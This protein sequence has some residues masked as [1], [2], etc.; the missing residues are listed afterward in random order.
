MKELFQ[1][2]P[3]WN[4]RLNWFVM[5]KI[6]HYRDSH[7]ILCGKSTLMCWLYLLHFL[8]VYKF[9]QTYPSSQ[10]CT[11]QV[12]TLIATILI[13]FLQN[14]VNKLSVLFHVSMTFP[15]MKQRRV[16]SVKANVINRIYIAIYGKILWKT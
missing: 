15:D 8:L 11:W 14:F 12:V 13:K 5:L 10:N 7:Q 9:R 6:Q 4:L 2:A 16:S 1:P 3:R